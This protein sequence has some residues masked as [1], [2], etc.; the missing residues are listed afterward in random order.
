MRRRCSPALRDKD[1]VNPVSEFQEREIAVAGEVVPTPVEY[2]T[3]HRGRDLQRALTAKQVAHWLRVPESE[4]EH[5]ASTGEIPARKVAGAW[6]FGAVALNRW[7]EVHS[8]PGATP[9]PV[10][11][12]LEE[13][14]RPMVVSRSLEI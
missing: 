1:E 11:E 2:E 14:S 9:E 7:I 3:F 6:R 5:L 10:I 4:V 8:D 12:K 13:I